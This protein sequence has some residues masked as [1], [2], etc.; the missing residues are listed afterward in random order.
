MRLLLALLLGLAAA[1]A[2]ALPVSVDADQDGRVDTLEAAL[3]SDAGDAASTPESHSVLPTCLDGEDNDLDGLVD[4]A[5]PGCRV[6]E[7]SI[8]SFPAAGD[9]VFETTLE[10]ERYPLA[11]PFGVCEIDVSARGAAV[12]H[13]GDPSPGGAAPSEI[14]TELVA[15]QVDGTAEI[16][17]HVPDCQLP[18]S[19]F[20]VTIFEDPAQASTGKITDDNPD[21]ALDFP[22]AS[23]FELYF[24]V[25]WGSQTVI[26]GGPDGGPPG[27]A[28]HLENRINGLP[29]WL[30]RSPD[31]YGGSHP[32]SLCSVAPPGSYLCYKSRFLFLE[33]GAGK[34]KVF[35]ADE[36]D[37]NGSEHKLLGPARFCTPVRWDDDPI[38]DPV[39]HLACFKL[40]PKKT[41]APLF[42]KSKLL[43]EA[44]QS[45][46]SG[47]STTQ[48]STLDDYECYEDRDTDRFPPFER[49]PVTLVDSFGTI[50]TDVIEPSMRCNPVR[51]EGPIQNP[52]RPLECFDLDPRRVRGTADLV[53]HGA[54]PF[55]TVE[56]TRAV[57]L[58][59]PTGWNETALP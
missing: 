2:G 27:A 18:P 6:P 45:N 12:V 43:C 50:E 30:G 3:G 5:D 38:G 54:T 47:F 40:K 37:P 39:G 34:G 10:L 58:C 23:S 13:R 9:D 42:W 15:L 4:L 44:V 7:A 14:D 35:L 55:A 31:C 16:L 19:T 32:F 41:G 59:V 33:P 8:A 49:R 36:F 53:R 22:A 56:T 20:D 26:P 11:T 1:P 17:S 52:L 21:P 48:L 24:D 46:L 57:S 25:A 51:L 28:L 29:A